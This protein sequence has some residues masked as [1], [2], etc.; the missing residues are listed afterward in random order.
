MIR[1][2]VDPAIDAAAHADKHRRAI[3]T[4]R[5]RQR[6][7]L[8]DTI[9]ENYKIAIIVKSAVASTHKIVDRYAGRLHD[10]LLL[11]GYLVGLDHGTRDMIADVFCAYKLVYAGVHQHLAHIILDTRQHHFNALFV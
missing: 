9:C 4:R 5:R 8:I 10:R 1:A 6:P 7:Q 3:N 2:I 11:A